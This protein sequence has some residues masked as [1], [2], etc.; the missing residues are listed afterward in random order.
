[1]NADLGAAIREAGVARFRPILL[2]SLTTFFGLGPLMLERSVD[3]AFLLPMAVSL[4]FGVIFATFIT[5]ILVPTAYLIV[6]DI[7]RLVARAAAAGAPLE[8]EALVGD[9]RRQQ[10]APYNRAA[11][12]AQ[13]ASAGAARGE[14]A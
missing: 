12:R 6:E 1:M 11:R 7:R 4:A 14:G 8:P 5:L 13:R 10:P 9:V 2:T 3:A